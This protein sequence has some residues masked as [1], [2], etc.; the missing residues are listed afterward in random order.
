MTIT[1]CHQHVVKISSKYCQLSIILVKMPILGAQITTL[2]ANDDNQNG[3]KFWLFF[4]WVMPGLL[5]NKISVSKSN[6][7]LNP[8]CVQCNWSWFENRATSNENK[9]KWKEIGVKFTK[10]ECISQSLNQTPYIVAAEWFMWGDQHLLPTLT[11]H[12]WSIPRLYIIISCQCNWTPNNVKKLTLWDETKSL[13]HGEQQVSI[14]PKWVTLVHQVRYTFILY[15]PYA[16]FLYLRN[17]TQ[18]SIIFWVKALPAISSV[19][20]LR[21]PNLLDTA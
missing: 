4:S 2:S 16:L 7:I 1:K 14:F 3:V 17:P 21:N 10:C 9:E 15:I 12:I 11:E 8:K 20:Y 5:P 19:L 6:F 18:R 13:I